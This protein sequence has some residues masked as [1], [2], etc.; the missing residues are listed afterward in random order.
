MLNVLVPTDFSPLS[1]VAVQYAIQ[2]ASELKAKI[3]LLHVIDLPKPTRVS[4]HEKIRRLEEDTIRLAERDMHKLIKSVTK[5]LEEQLKLDQS[6]I[7][8][9]DFTGV[10]KKESKRLKTDLVVMGTKGATGLKKSLVGSNT[11]AVI[12]T[13]DIPVLVVPDKAKFKGF[14]Q[15]I[16]ATDMRNL[17]KELK[18]I[19][20]YAAQF[21]STIHAV[22]VTGHGADLGSLETKMDKVVAKLKYKNV[23]T[24]VLMDEDIESALEQYIA[25]CKADAL[26]MFTHDINFFEKLFDRSYTRRMAFQSKVP[27][28]S[29]KKRK[30]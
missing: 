24:M 14:R 22:H 8:S 3:T 20:V 30:S 19:H 18:T 10:L 1:K 7:Q 12:E 11:T 15:I 2:I 13:L 6:I 16:Y 27:L 9:T 23:V 26:T 28:L 21:G 17:E 4:M 29:F 25:L 5:D